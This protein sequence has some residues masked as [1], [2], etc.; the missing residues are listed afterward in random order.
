MLGSSMHERRIA[1]PRRRGRARCTPAPRLAGHMSD[2]SHA[3]EGRH[4]TEAERAVQAERR[5]RRPVATGRTTPD[6]GGRTQIGSLRCRRARRVSHLPRSQHRVQHPQPHQRRASWRRPVPGHRACNC[7]LIDGSTSWSVHSWGAA[8]DTNWQRNPRY[9]DY[10]N[11]RGFDGQNHGT[12]IPDVWRGGFPGI[13]S[14][15]GSTG[16]RRP[17]PCTSSTSPT[18]ESFGRR[19]QAMVRKLVIGLTAMIAVGAGLVSGQE[20]S[21]SAARARNRARRDAATPELRSRRG[22][23]PRDGSRCLGRGRGHLVSAAAGRSPA[24][25]PGGERSGTWRPPAGSAP[26]TSSIVPAQTRSWW[27]HASRAASPCTPKRRTRRGLPTARSRLGDGRGVAI[28][29]HDG[30]RIVRIDGPV[31]GGTVFSRCSS[32]RPGWLRSLLGLLHSAPEGGQYDDLWVTSLDGGG[33][34]RVTSFRASG[35]RWV[36]SNPCR[37]RRHAVLRPCQRS[38]FGNGRATVR[39]LAIRT[40]DRAERDGCPASDTWPVPTRAIRSGMC[41]IPNTADSC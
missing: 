37:R 31:S 24:P 41:P 2:W 25:G 1:R 13:A 18:T 39:A 8:V 29:P 15:G 6:R 3:L 20:R 34:R 9:Q 16:T 10:W 35:D 27:S 22:V 7:R 4:T 32:R 23:R 30:G 12:Y 36:I 26:P 28:L 19:R 17:T 38:R 11:G 14:S 40:G 5:L 21:D 33:W